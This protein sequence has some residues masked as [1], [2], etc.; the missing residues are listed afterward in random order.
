MF[1]ET[2]RIRNRIGSPNHTSRPWKIDK[3]ST[4]GSFTSTCEWCL[5]GVRRPQ[6]PP[7]LVPVEGLSVRRES[8]P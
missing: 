7:I 5:S 1:C 6:E 4:A 8:R 3:M 2:K